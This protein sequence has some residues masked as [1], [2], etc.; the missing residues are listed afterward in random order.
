VAL[1]NGQNT[2]SDAKHK[3]SVISNQS[4]FEVERYIER[5]SPIMQTQISHLV[6]GD[7]LA[8]VS[9]FITPSAA[10]AYK[11]KKPISIGSLNSYTRELEDHMITVIGEVP[12]RTVAMIAKN[13]QL[14]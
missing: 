4:G 10:S 7:G 5:I 1:S 3:W 14:N 9:V 8:K 13:T 12:Q 6:L 11:P 2:E